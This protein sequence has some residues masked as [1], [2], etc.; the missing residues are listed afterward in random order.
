MAPNA[1]ITEFIK[2]AGL[3]QFQTRKVQVRY[4]TYGLPDSIGSNIYKI[5]FHPFSTK[6]GRYS[7]KWL[8]I[9]IYCCF[10]Y[11]VKVQ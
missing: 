3:L 7:F 9:V 4:I 6:T 5:S 10:L 11:Q 1:E 2:T 8:I